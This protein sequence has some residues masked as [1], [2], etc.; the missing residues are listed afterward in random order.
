MAR[1]MDPFTKAVTAI[2]RALQSLPEIDRAKALAAVSVATQLSKE[3]VERKPRAK[4]QPEG[5]Q[6]FP[7]GTVQ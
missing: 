5:Q 4:K 1:K 6:T 3:P 2:A 7:P